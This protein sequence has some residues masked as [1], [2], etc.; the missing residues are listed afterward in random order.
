MASLVQ[1]RCLSLTPTLY[2]AA[3]QLQDHDLEAFD[4]IRLGYMSNPARFFSFCT[5]CPNVTELACGPLQN[6][7]LPA[8][9]SSRILPKLKKFKGPVELS[10]LLVPGRPVE[11]IRA[12][13]EPHSRINIY[14]LVRSLATSSHAVRLLYLSGVAWQ[15]GCVEEIAA[16][17]PHVESVTLDFGPSGYPEVSKNHGQGY[18]GT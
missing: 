15:E 1:V 8:S 13:A 4:Q 2:E 10:R 11:D 12:E 18:V 6:D 14:G 3:E 17:L 9:V 7:P 16:H 5:R